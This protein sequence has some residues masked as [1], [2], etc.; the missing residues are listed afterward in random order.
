MVQRLEADEP[1]ARVA[2]A[3]HLSPR[4]VREWWGPLSGPGGDRA[5]GPLEPAA[6]LAPGAAP[7]SAAAP[8]SSSRSMT[9]KDP[10][11][12]TIHIAS[13]KDA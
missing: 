10:E 5:A 13:S 12:G 4:R 9:A 8:A 11:Y 3:V 7:V 1:V 6:S 2:Q